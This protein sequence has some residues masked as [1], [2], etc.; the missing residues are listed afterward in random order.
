MASNVAGRA[1]ADRFDG[2]LPKYDVDCIAPSHGFP[3]AQ[4]TSP[5]CAPASPR[6]AENS[7]KFA[8]AQRAK[9]KKIH[10]RKINLKALGR[11][12]LGNRRRRL[13]SPK[14]FHPA[15]NR[16]KDSPPTNRRRLGEM[17]LHMHRPADY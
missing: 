2:R 4:N 12:E 9:Y 5:F 1:Y 10:S 16:A 3:S 11:A 6:S 17:W 15:E 7:R 8:G 14:G 13:L